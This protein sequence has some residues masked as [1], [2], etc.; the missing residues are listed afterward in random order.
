MH[1]YITIE[2]FKLLKKSFPSSLVE[3]ESFLGTNETKNPNS[4][5]LTYGLDE[6][7][8]GAWMEDEYDVVHYYGTIFYPS[9]NQTL[10]SGQIINLLGGSSNVAFRSITH[11]WNADNGRTSS[12]FLNDKASDFYWS[13]TIPENAFT[14]CKK[15]ADGFGFLFLYSEVVQMTLNC[16]KQTMDGD[17]WWY[18]SIENVYRGSNTSIIKQHM[19][20]FHG[21]FANTQTWFDVVSGCNRA[22]DKGR[23]YNILGR[24]CHLLQDQAVPEHV[25]CVSHANTKGMRRSKYEE[26]CSAYHQWTADEIWSKGLTYLNPFFHNGVDNDPIYNL[27]YFLNQIT[28]HYASVSVNGDNTFDS[29]F[30]FLSRI[31]PNLGAPTVISEIN[32]VNCKLMHEQIQSYAIRA[33][34]GLMYW[35][36][37]KTGQLPYQ[38]CPEDVNISN[39]TIANADDITYLARRNLTLSDNGYPFLI[40][41]GANSRAYAGSCIVLKP[42][43]V[44]EAGSNFSASIAPEFASVNVPISL[45]KNAIDSSVNDILNDKLDIQNG[46]LVGNPNPFNPTTTICFQ[47]PSSSLNVHNTR[48][49]LKIY[50]I[51]GKLIQILNDGLVMPGKHSIVWN[52]RDSNGNSVPSGVYLCTLVSNVYCST[53]KLYMTK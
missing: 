51:S 46:L 20:Q 1:Q 45:P 23:A 30:P 16:G 8:S 19:W 38:P 7:V 29:N 40:S 43:F 9:F 18:P 41:A 28:D 52:G 22:G 50:D 44:A 26:E 39:A 53:I 2:A 37:V 32:D 47:F 31:I 49:S 4:Y 36:A 10:A 13:F 35:F 48:F 14:K 42:G 33:T 12:T 17:I 3:M 21:E 27:M 15:H 6:I 5:C 11:F 34:A 25:H 24:M